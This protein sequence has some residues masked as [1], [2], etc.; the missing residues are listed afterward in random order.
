MLR[1]VDEQLD[2]RRGEPVRVTDLSVACGVSVRTLHNVFQ[3][4]HGVSPMEYV[5]L[6]RLK[7][8]HRM[9]ARGDPEETT[10]S[11]AALRWGFWHPGA[12]SVLYRRTFGERPSETLR[13]RC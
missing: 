4:A 13:R 3:E 8:V 6:R 1:T 2:T 7:A 5:R 9:L 11:E 12:F 10:V